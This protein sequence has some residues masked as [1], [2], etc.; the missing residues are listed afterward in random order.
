[1]LLD[2]KEEISEA[3]GLKR[4]AQAQIQSKASAAKGAPSSRPC[5]H[6]PFRCAPD[7]VA[8]YDAAPPAALE[9]LAHAIR[10]HMRAAM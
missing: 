9:T 8:E 6:D 1:M 7:M 10:A 4:F 5:P 2:A 3:G